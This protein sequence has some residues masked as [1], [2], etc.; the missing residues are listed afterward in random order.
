[1]RGLADNPPTLVTSE[2]PAKDVTK[3]RC[4]DRDWQLILMA[5]V[6]GHLQRMRKFRDLSTTS[7][8]TRVRNRD[9]A[10][11]N[12]APFG[13]PA[14]I[15]SWRLERLAPTGKTGRTQSVDFPFWNS[16]NPSS[17]ASSV[18][19]TLAPICNCNRLDEHFQFGARDRF[20]LFAVE[21]TAVHFR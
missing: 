9:P 12:G 1:M 15:I 7:A 13:A 16:Y 10:V 18:L 11:N 21:F 3:L 2:A 5:C 14:I 19:R 17:V 20:R 6:A 8:P 4:S